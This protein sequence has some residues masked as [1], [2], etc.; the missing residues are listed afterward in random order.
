MSEAWDHA[1]AKGDEA[2]ALRN[3]EIVLTVPASFD[4]VAREL[5]VE[6]AYAAGLEN[7]TL[8]EEPQAALYAWLSRNGNG[9]RKLLHPGDLLLVVDVG[10]GT[11]DFS[12]IRVGT[13]YRDRTDRSRDV[14][15][16]AGVHIG[17]TDFDSALSLAS[18]MP[19]L[20]LGTRLV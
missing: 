1:I 16:T 6:A 14:L 13:Q 19:L 5:T 15:A 2:L 4:A 17:G 12:I 8:L 9:W 3:Q 10:G 11:S 20:G 18:V 7:V